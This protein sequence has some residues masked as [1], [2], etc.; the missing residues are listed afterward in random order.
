MHLTSPMYKIARTRTLAKIAYYKAHQS[1]SDSRTV[2]VENGI[3]LYDKKF[4]P[5]HQ[6][7]DLVKE[8]LVSGKQGEYIAINAY[9][10][11]NN[12]NENILQDLRKWIRIKT[13]LATM[14]GFGPRFLHSTGQLHKGGANNGIFL[15]ITAEPVHDLEIPE[16]DS[17]LEHWNMGKH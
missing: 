10:T 13:G 4:Q 16:T 14:V 11:R 3:K 15:V 17:A 9:L 7:S 8:F 1:F 5:G 12:K 2:Y 6:L